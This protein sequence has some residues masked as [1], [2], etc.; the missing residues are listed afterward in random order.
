MHDGLA[1]V[2]ARLQEYAERGVFRGLAERPARRG[3][4]EFT[5]RWLAPSPFTLS[6]DP[7]S[8]ALTFRDLLPSVPARSPLAAALRR[9]IRSR[10]AAGLKAPISWN[11]GAAG[12]VRGPNRLKTVRTPSAERT[13]MIAFMAG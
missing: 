12:L 9:F 2:R 13:G 4:Y 1:E 7:S 6:Y 11:G 5:F 10:A 8:G 3:R